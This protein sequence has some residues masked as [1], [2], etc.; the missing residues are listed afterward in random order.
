[1]LASLPPEQLATFLKRTSDREL[2]AIEHDWG[3]WG[4]CNQQA[5][6][7]DWRTWL[8]L[9][10]R[11]FGKTRS[12]AECIRDQVI[13]HRRRR[14]A[15]VA[16]TAADARD[17]MVEGE[18]GLLAI[19]PPQQRPQY[20]PTKR[21]LTWPNGAIATT[22][23][24]DEP[25]RLRGPQHDAAWCDEI[26][27]W[28]YPEAWDMLMF[29]L[30]LGPDPRVVVTTTPKPV[31]IIREL[32]T[33]PT[34]VVT[35]GSS[36]ENRANLADAFFAQIIR[37]YEGTRLGRQEIEAELLDDV[38]GALWNRT[39]LEELRW[40]LYKSVPDLVRIVVAIDPATTSGED[41][42]ETG[43]IVAG[44]D[45][46]GRGYVL[47]DRS[48][49]YTPTEWAQL[50]IALYRQH[51]ADRIVAEVNNGGDMVEATLRMIDP[52]VPYTA[53]HASRGKVVRAEPVAALYEQQP[54]RVFHVGTFPTMEDQMCAFTTDFDRK[55]AGFSPDRVDALVW[56]LSDLLVEPEPGAAMIEFYRLRAREAA[57]KKAAA[58]AVPSA[59]RRCKRVNARGRCINGER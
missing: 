10:G 20:E 19:G 59:T 53:V 36:Y 49:H 12:G 8:L 17:V 18:S 54:G 48:G 41:A 55:T 28:R 13:H 31:K 47:A 52:N 34:T 33:D 2:E 43:I 21:R 25:E 50:A 15:L 6:K 42:D 58:E 40:P 51:K 46:G 22:Y 7:G 37:K 4:R 5:P 14:I 3:W 38:P 45:G 29:G 11:G 26:A 39:R 57:E 44:K 30:R 27:S 35:R 24:A 16:P 23:S 32:L 9:A 56:A 1:M